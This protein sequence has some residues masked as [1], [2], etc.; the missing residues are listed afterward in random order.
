MA[1]VTENVGSYGAVAVI[2]GSDKV[3][4]GTRLG[5]LL[6]NSTGLGHTN[7]ALSARVSYQIRPVDA[8]NNMAKVPFE[9]S[10]AIS[11]ARLKPHRGAEIVDPRVSAAPPQQTT[12]RYGI[13]P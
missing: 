8:M 9:L 5:G 7:R 11:R 1:N 10:A 2:V 4:T 3:I 12:F 13:S 6:K